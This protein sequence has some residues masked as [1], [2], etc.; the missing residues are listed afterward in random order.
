MYIIIHKQNG[1]IGGCEYDNLEDAL[2]DVKCFEDS[3]RY[4]GEYEP[5]TYEIAGVAGNGL[6][7]ERLLEV[8]KAPMWVNSDEWCEFYEKTEDAVADH[9]HAIVNY[10]TVDG[11][12]I[13]TVEIDEGWLS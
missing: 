12:G 8:V 4:N 5:N 9:P 13:L 2:Y 3:D 11:D 6:K 7:L 10:I 1:C